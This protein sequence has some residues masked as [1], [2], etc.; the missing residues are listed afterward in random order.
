MDN[1][2][3]RLS[4]IWVKTTKKRLTIALI[5]CLLV[6]TL[7]PAPVVKTTALKELHG[8]WMT[9]LGVALMYY[10]TRLD[11]TIAD[12]AKHKIN[13]LYP[14][15]WNHGHTLFKS[16]VMQQAGGRNRN[17]W[18]TLPLPWNDPIAGLVTQTHRQHL[19]L[20]PWFEYGLM[21]PTDAD[22]IKRHPD[23]L[24]R[25]QN[26]SSLPSSLKSAEK[27]P[28]RFPNPMN[29]LYHA[30]IG[31]DQAWLNP[32]HPEVQ[33]FLTDLIV[34]VVTRYDV[35]GIQLDDHF[36]L[37]IEYGYDP[38]TVKLY[39]ADHAGKVPPRDP[40]NPAWIK[41]RADRLTQLMVKIHAAVKAA[42]PTAIVSLSPNAAD[43]AY[44][45]SLQDWSQW[46]KQGLLD[47]V[48]VQLYRPTI[49]SLQTELDRPNLKA[50]A[51]K[52][53]VSI[54]LYT[55]PFRQAKPA[56]RIAQEVQAVRSAGYAGTSF[57]CWETTFW[58]FRG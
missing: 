49:A 33:Q 57:F 9:H 2:R 13:T 50:I 55:G 34:E 20:I 27:S 42:R 45:T 54:G 3:L 25:S 37:P 51:Q 32:F 17:P 4:K 47:E 23:W 28:Y 19:R 16:Q 22:V 5:S 10:S 30:V 26:Q 53:P 6:I 7:W 52:V 44:R 48:I 43:F 12:L 36:G 35:D 56:H 18:M 21:I 15:V 24:A 38:Y 1:A 8:T 58:L 40:A 14:A 31:Q 41:W 29:S 11:D 39:Q 46:V